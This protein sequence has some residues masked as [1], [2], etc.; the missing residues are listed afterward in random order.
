MVKQ[1]FPMAVAW[2]HATSATGGGVKPGAMMTAA[3][4]STSS[5]PASMSELC[6]ERVGPVGQCLVTKLKGAWS[7]KERQV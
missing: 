5:A 6:G 7:C 2:G 1:R 4:A 3:S